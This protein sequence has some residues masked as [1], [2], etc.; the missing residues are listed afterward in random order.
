MV[1][2]TAPNMPLKSLDIM[3]ETYSSLPVHVADHIWHAKMP[4]KHQKIIDVR[5]N[6]FVSG[7][8]SNAP[9]MFPAI[10]IDIE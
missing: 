3:K 5:P 2:G 10:A 9:A 1:S 8:R 7:I 4:T 6:T